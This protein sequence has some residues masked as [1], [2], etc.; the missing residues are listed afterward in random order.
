MAA[1]IEWILVMMTMHKRLIAT[2]TIAA[3]LTVPM[4]AMAQSRDHR[5][6]GHRGGHHGGS[7][8]DNTGAYIGLGLG[9]A[10]LGTALALSATQQPTYEAPPTYYY[11][12]A[13][14]PTYYAPAP[15]PA[16]YAQP[17]YYYA[18]APAPAYYQRP[19]TYYA[20][21][22]YDPYTS[23]YKAYPSYD[24]GSN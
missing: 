13:P 20:P 7:H 10:A 14:A 15:A 18:P 16:Y 8:Q 9:A 23:S 6:G 1:E 19:T 11:A 3:L 2:A 17:T 24:R 5:G 12:P 21:G 22:Y 4:A